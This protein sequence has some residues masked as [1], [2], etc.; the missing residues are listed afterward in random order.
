MKCPAR[1]RKCCPY[2]NPEHLAES[3]FSNHGV[4]GKS[5]YHLFKFGRV[6]AVGTTPVIQ[7]CRDV[8]PGGKV[9]D[10]L[11]GSSSHRPV[12]RFVLNPPENLNKCDPRWIDATWR[13]WLSL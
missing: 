2:S 12:V 5:C 6:R 10:L 11:E 3:L 13:I 8:R 9:S 1:I 7:T 4:V